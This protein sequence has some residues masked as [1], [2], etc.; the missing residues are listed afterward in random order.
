MK[1]QLSLLFTL[2]SLLNTFGQEEMKHYFVYF[3]YDQYELIEKEQAKIDSIIFSNRETITKIELVGHT[4]SDGSDDYNLELSKKRVLAVQDYLLQKGVDQKMIVLNY[5]G[6]GK[7]VDENSSEQG[8][9][10]NR[11]VELLVYFKQKY[12]KPPIVPT[13][14]TEEEEEE[15]EVSV[16]PIDSIPLQDQGDTILMIDGVQ[17]VISKKDHK[18]FKDC[19]MIRPVMTGEEALNNGLTTMTLDNDFLVSCGMISIELKPPCEGCFDKPI[20]VRFPVGNGDKNCDICKNRVV[21][22][23]S[24]NGRWTENAGEKVRRVNISGQYFYEMIIKCPGFKNCDCPKEA[25]KVKFKIP[26]KYK[27]LKFHIVYNCPVGVYTFSLKR[28]KA[29]NKIPCALSDRVAY[30][31]F[32]ATN[33]NGDTIRVDRLPISELKHSIWK[34]CKRGRG[35]NKFLIFKTWKHKVYSTYRIRESGIEKYKQKN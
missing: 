31:Y 17:I 34:A 27:L 5:W 22:D 25:K 24:R 12:I 11:R 33:K 32:E 23:I 8:K 9:Q 20:K 2:V 1:L 6:E 18:K 15:E 21:Y 4:D 29:E 13:N 14:E 30:V 16:A 19:L 26:R 7:P 35:E 28:N 10:N 3:D